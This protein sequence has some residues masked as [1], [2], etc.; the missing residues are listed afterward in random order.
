MQWL[1]TVPDILTEAHT[2]STCLRQGVFNMHSCSMSLYKLSRTHKCNKSFTCFIFVAFVTFN[3]F[4]ILITLSF[5]QTLSKYHADDEN[6]NTN[7]KHFRNK[8]TKK[9]YYFFLCESSNLKNHTDSL[10]TDFD[11]FW[12]LNGYQKPCQYSYNDQKDPLR[13]LEL[14]FT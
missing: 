2:T 12:L 11:T 8:T 4:F 5:S 10:I 7:H 9:C 6:L 1:L 3:G 13:S 14:L